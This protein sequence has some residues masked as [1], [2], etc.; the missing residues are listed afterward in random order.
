MKPRVAVI[1]PRLAYGGSETGAMWTLEALKRDY[2][3]T[4]V[5]GGAVDL[6]RLNSYYGTNHRRGE[7]KIHEMRMPLWLDRTAK[8]AGLRGALFTRECRRLT[9]GFDVI[10][11]HYNPID[12]GVPLIQFVADFSF[13]P[14]FQRTLDPGTTQY[15]QWWYGDSTLRRVYLSVCDRLA[16]QRPE[17]WKQNITVA[18]SRWTAGLLEK[19]FGIITTRV[20]FPPVPGR[21]PAIPWNLKEDGFVCLGRMVPEKGLDEVIRLLHQVRR[22]NFKIH[23]HILGRLDASPSARQIWQLAS[24]HSDWVHCEGLVT[25]QAKRELMAR[26]RY[27]INGCRREAFGIAVAEL[28]KAGCITFVPNGGG[29]TEIVGHPALTFTDENDAV[30]KIESVLASRGLQ[31]NLHRHLAGRAQELS[32]EKFIRTARELVSEFLRKK[33]RL[34]EINPERPRVAFAAL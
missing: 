28:V 32:T 7:F 30:T 15:W 31:Q 33:Q 9:A 18:N 25:G 14:G 23:L 2:E 4:L 27:G 8:F 3:V 13:A 10:T 26:H 12:L 1:H 16:P 29:Q 21:F 11:A 6:E 20:Q 34:A 17:N 19:N 5:S 22:H 24:R